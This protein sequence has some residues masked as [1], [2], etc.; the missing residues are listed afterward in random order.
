MKRSDKSPSSSH[1]SKA[2]NAAGLPLIIDYG[3]LSDIKWPG[4]VSAA[5]MIA[6]GKTSE[7]VLNEAV[8]T[9]NEFYVSVSSAA[10]TRC[11]DGRHDPELDEQKLGAQVPGGAPGAALAYRLGVDK[12]D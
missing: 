6:S 12:D 8:K 2:K 3:V 5:A 4:K 9:I 11:I 7:A 10:R 1:L